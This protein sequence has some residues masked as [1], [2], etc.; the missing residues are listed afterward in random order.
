VPANYVKILGLRRGNKVK[1]NA[2][3]CTSTDSNSPSTSAQI[4]QASSSSG[5]AD[6]KTDCCSQKAG[7]SNTDVTS[8]NTET[9]S[10]DFELPA[11][12]EMDLL[13]DVP[14]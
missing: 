8:Q 7:T 2:G 12:T 5:S 10:L 14:T 13:D 9:N 3:P 11:E 4:P 1:P 6:H